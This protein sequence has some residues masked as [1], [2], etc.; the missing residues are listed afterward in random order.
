MEIEE[1]KPQSKASCYERDEALIGGYSLE[2][3]ERTFSRYL[4]KFPNNFSRDASGSIASLSFPRE[5]CLL[6]TFCLRAT[7][8]ELPLSLPPSPAA[9]LPAT[10]C[11]RAQG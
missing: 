9:F 5:K 6:E 4:S 10:D 3:R 11:S 1:L 7:I 8:R 2:F